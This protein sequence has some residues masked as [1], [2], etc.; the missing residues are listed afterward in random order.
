MRGRDRYEI[1]LAEGDSELVVESERSE[2]VDYRFGEE[3][4]GEK[5]E[6]RAKCIWI[7]RYSSGEAR[8][9]E[10]RRRIAREYAA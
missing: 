2:S 9:D 6:A 4:R 3:K 8:R 10:T 7:L 5:T 1:E